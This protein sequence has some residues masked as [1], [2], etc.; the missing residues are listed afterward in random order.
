VFDGIPDRLS[1]QSPDFRIL[2]LNRAVIEK[3]HSSYRELL[4]KKCYETYYRRSE[5]CESCPVAATLQSQQPT[6]SLMKIPEE[7]ATLRVY[8]YPIL[9]ERGNLVSVIEH[10]HDITEEERLQAQ[11]IQSEK[12]AGIGVL[13]SGVAHEINNPLTGVIGMAEAAMEEED[14]PTV[15]SYL[16]DILT[17][18][19]RIAEIVQGLRSY[20]RASKEGEQSLL[21]INDV[22][23]N[24]LKMVRLGMKADEVTVRENF[25]P[26]E[27]I[28]ANLGEIQ[29]VFIN[30]I[31][32]AFQ[33]IQGKKGTVTLSTQSLNGGIEAKVSDDG[34]GI[35][36]RYLNR[37][38]DPFFTTKKAGEGTGLG[39]NIAYRIVTKYGG[40]IQVDSQENRGTTFTVRFPIK[41][42]ER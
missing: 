27:R 39:L 8:A 34:I 10:V 42:E 9:D 14:L 26:V 16:S 20:C 28:E 30:L 38:F 12:L 17:C 41:K 18:S 5:P 11:L 36:E 40:T 23:E 33:A 35:P 7:D 19:Q 37:I 29:Q 15:R 31:T 3:Y 22:L 24:S 25:Q 1:V 32:N 2:R 13:A 4:G 6:S 21:D